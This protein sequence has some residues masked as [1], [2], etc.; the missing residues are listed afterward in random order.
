MLGYDFDL[1]NEALMQ[2]DEE[3]ISDEDFMKSLSK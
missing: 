3:V 1:T 2:D